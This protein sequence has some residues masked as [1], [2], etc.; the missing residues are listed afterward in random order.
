MKD[1]INWKSV[2]IVIAGLG[3]LTLVAGFL[4]I[5][6]GWYNVGATSPHSL[7]V[8]KTLRY[9]MEQSVRNHASEVRIPPGINLQDPVLA[10]NAIGHYSIAC[11]PCHAAPR[12]PKAS[13]MVLYPPPPPLTDSEVVENWSD[14]ELF[15]IIKNGIKD[16]G[17]IALPPGHSDDDV[18]AIAAFVR[19]LPNMTSEHY[20][21]LVETYQANSTHSTHG[22]VS[23]Q[24]KQLK[25]AH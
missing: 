17:M 21:T 9:T 18:W 10:E 19:Q 6:N 4:V 7:L 23:E 2:I 5:S 22:S 16:T 25:H 11:A 12:E 1:K 8:E 20:R 24:N 15:W 13:W 14:E 3:A